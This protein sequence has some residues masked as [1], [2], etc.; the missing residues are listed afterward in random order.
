[1][2]FNWGWICPPP[3]PS[4]HIWQCWWQ[5]WLSQMEGGWGACVTGI[6]WVEASDAAKCTTMSKEA[7]Q[8]QR[9]IWPQMSVVPKLRNGTLI[10]MANVK[11]QGFIY[12]LM[13]YRRRCFPGL[14]L[15]GK[16]VL[17]LGITAFFS[18]GS[19]T[20]SSATCLEFDWV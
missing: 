2:V 15:G 6:Y 3:P 7:A 20:T 4:K 16:P 18:Q 10:R 1:M 8:Q 14:I 11:V 9:I 12:N 5:F 13:T 19:K 17:T